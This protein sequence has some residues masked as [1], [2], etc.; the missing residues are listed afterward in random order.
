MDFSSFVVASEI[1][2]MKYPSNLMT[3]PCPK[4]HF[5]AVWSEFV[6]SVTLGRSMVGV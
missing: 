6:T 2:L 5:I 1:T 4:V 3:M